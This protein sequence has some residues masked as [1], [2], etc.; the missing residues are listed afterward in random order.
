MNN[1]LIVIVFLVCFNI[2]AQEFKFKDV[3]K[4]ELL[5]EFHVEDVNIII[6]NAQFYLSLKNFF[7]QI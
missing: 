1:L 6:P 7:C 2:S 4:E 5:E 3:S